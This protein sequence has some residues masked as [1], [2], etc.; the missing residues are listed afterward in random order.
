[1]PFFLKYFIPVLLLA[2]TA[3]ATDTLRTLQ[4][5]SNALLLGNGGEVG[6]LKDDLSDHDTFEIG[7]M[8]FAPASLFEPWDQGRFRIGYTKSAYWLRLDLTDTTDRKLILEL[9][10]PY[11]SQ[12]RFYQVADGEVLDTLTVGSDIPFAGRRHWN[13]RDTIRI[14]AGDTVRCLLNIPYNRSLT[15]FNL[16]LTDAQARA[17]FDRTERLLLIVFFCLILVYLLMLGLAIN[18]T[19]FRYYWFYFAYVL[20]VSGYIFADIGLGYQ[21]LWPKWPYVQ[22]VSLPI[23][24]NAYLIAGAMFVM[25][26]FH[27]RRSYPIQHAAL[28]AVSF[29]AAAMVF[30]ALLLP[31]LTPF[32]AHLYANFSGAMYIVTVLLFFWLAGTA[33]LRDDRMFPGWLMVGFLV[34]GASVIYSSLEQFKFVPPLSLQSILAENGLLITFHTPLVLMVGLLVDMGIVLLIGV[35]R[36]RNMLA[37]SQRMTRELAEQR[38]Q[39]LNALALGMETEQRR[40]AQ[41]LHDGLGG[42][43]AAA[44]FKL[45]KILAEKSGTDPALGEV[46][47]ELTDIHQELREIA[48]NLM[49]KHLH[50]QG[51][52]AAVEQLVRRMEA[53][54]PKLKISFYNNADLEELNELASVYLYRIV[55]EL[56]A[57]LL[58]HSDAT[59]AYLQF[60]KQEN[61]LLVTLEDNGKGFDMAGVSSPLMVGGKAGG[62][63]LANIR[64]RVEDAL[65]GKFQMESSPGQGCLTTIELPWKGIL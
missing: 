29:V 4:L 27:T 10:N 28:R 7:E 50:K 39:N 3:L 17:K 43:I 5:G 30:T 26:H 31:V 59:E 41:E 21:V 60:V 14:P 38:K 65:G 63:G 18:L 22:Q 62:M 8:M 1:M 19:R 53:A 32:W 54:A 47:G 6:I 40:I 55:Q 57:N 11:L 23:F 25:A 48:H 56:L 2:Q 20:L 64:Y 16:F 49:P 42:S 12:M 44:K 15:D 34:H 35:K 46:V 13:L 36:F 37:E 45:E 52:L 61:G 9:D 58:K 51:L 33:F 24:A